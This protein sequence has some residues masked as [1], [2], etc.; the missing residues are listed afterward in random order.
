MFDATAKFPYNSLAKA[1]RLD[2]GD[3]DECMEIDHKYDKGRI[4]GKYCFA[5]LLIPDPTD[6]NNAN[7]SF[8][9]FQKYVFFA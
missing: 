1:T 4:L 8:H 7:V 3:Y 2:Y 5:G 6:L 9:D